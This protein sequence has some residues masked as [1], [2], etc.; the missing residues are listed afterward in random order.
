MIVLHLSD[1]NLDIYSIVKKNRINL[2]IYTDNKRF[3]LN[4]LKFNTSE[5]QLL[6]KKP[7]NKK[8]KILPK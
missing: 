2:E 8:V 6:I 5:L 1:K 3:R 4:F 7:H